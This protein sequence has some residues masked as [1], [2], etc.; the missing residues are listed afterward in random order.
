MGRQRLV[1]GAPVLAGTKVRP[2]QSNGIGCPTRASVSAEG[3]YVWPKVRRYRGPR[4]GQVGSESIFVRRRA[5]SPTGG[6]SCASKRPH[7]RDVPLASNPEGSLAELSRPGECE[8]QCRV[9]L[10]CASQPRFQVG[11]S[12]VLDL[13]VERQGEVPRLQRRPSQEIVAMWGDGC[14]EVGYHV[15]RYQDRREEPHHSATIINGSHQ[16]PH[17]SRT[18][19]SFVLSLSLISSLPCLP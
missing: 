7:R 19:S 18:H 12:R 17:S 4:Q 6:R 2:D 15:R 9:S 11:H 13:A 16:Y 5:D 14:V 1:P 8:R 3:G 10:R